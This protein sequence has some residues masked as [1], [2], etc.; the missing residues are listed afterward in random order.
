M[1]PPLSRRKLLFRAGREVESQNE[2]QPL[3]PM[4]RGVL[5]AALRK[6]NGRERGW[7]VGSGALCLG[8][9]RTAAAGSGP[10][11]GWRWAAQFGGLRPGAGTCGVG[12]GPGK[13]GAGP[14][15]GALCPL[16]PGTRVRL[17]RAHNRRSIS[18]ELM[19]PLWPS[20]SSS[21][22]ESVQATSFSLSGRGHSLTS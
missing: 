6:T 16:R 19:C 13:A 21:Q 15:P 14:G 5:S 9:A 4:E 11:S 22:F 2:W 3:Q 7:V 17:H 10:R 18:A 20:P 12:G 1:R 8:L